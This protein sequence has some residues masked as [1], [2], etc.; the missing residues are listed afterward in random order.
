[1]KEERKERKRK[2]QMSTRFLPEAINSINP[3]ENGR[4]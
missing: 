2:R 4:R 1:M 3:S